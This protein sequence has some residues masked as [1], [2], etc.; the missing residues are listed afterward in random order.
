MQRRRLL[1]TGAGSALLGL[2]GCLDALAD[3]GRGSES[4]DLPEGMSVESYDWTGLV[5]EDGI[6]DRELGGEDIDVYHTL[7]TDRATAEDRVLP[8]AETDGFILDTDFATSYVVVVQN[9]MQSARWLE[10]SGIR[11]L[12]GGGLEVTVVSKEPDG[13][14]GDDA[15]PHSLVMRVTDEKAGI[16]TE[17]VVWLDGTRS[18]A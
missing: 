12:D 9:V 4:P 1:A 7:I 8:E 5:L 10:L 11:R 17:L 3:S 16:P 15:I 18:D 2:A 13:S 14:Y 6:R